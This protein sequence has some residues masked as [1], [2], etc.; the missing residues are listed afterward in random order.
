MNF[1]KLFPRLV[2]ACFCLTLSVTTFGQKNEARIRLANQIAAVAEVED[3]A[4]SKDD[5]PVI[6]S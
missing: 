1:T 5:D 4:F 6:I 2:A 3:P